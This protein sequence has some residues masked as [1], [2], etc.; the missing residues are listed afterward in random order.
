LSRNFSKNFS[1]V[2]PTEIVDLISD[3]V[4]ATQ[5]TNTRVHV[6]GHSYGGWLAIKMAAKIIASGNEID[7]L[8]TIDPISRDDCTY[9]NWTNCF[10]A[11]ID[12]RDETLAMI[13]NKTGYWA[14]YYQNTTY[15]LH[16]GRIKFADRNEQLDASHYDIDTH[17]TIWSNIEKRLERPRS[18]AEL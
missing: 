12:L 17:E 3:E 9:T 15:Y 11:P 13:Q 7:S 16:S 2:E 8:V 6:I 4:P 10:G 1:E 5:T 18:L 14:N